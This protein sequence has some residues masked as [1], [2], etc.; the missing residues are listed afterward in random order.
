MIKD[1]A[2]PMGIDE[3]LA[4]PLQADYV[5]FNTYGRELTHFYEMCKYLHHPELYA[6]R[7]L[8]REAKK[9]GISHVGGVFYCYQRSAITPELD[10]RQDVLIPTDV[11]LNLTLNY[12]GWILSKA[13]D[14]ARTHNSP[15]WSFGATSKLF[16][17]EEASKIQAHSQIGPLEELLIKTGSNIPHTS[18]FLLF[19]DI[20]QKSLPREK[21][22]TLSNDANSALWIGQTDRGYH[23]IFPHVFKRDE[24]LNRLEVRLAARLALKSEAIGLIPDLRNT[25][26]AVEDCEIVI[27]VTPRNNNKP[28]FV[29]GV[30]DHDETI[31]VGPDADRADY[32]VQMMVESVLERRDKLVD[33]KHLPS[34][35]RQ[36]TYQREL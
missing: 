22:I 3:S 36:T 13:R 14:L 2:G 6:V 24:D 25:L 31:R 1:G 8:W 23:L 20:D 30:I 34:G 5:R 28:P 4:R 29:S 32:F 19:S 9:L 7:R 16:T 26:H 11:A 21:F 27:R 10:L 35:V 12:D 33:V 15:P 17:H 18:H